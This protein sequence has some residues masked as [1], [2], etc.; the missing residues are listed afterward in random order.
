VNHEYEVQSKI[1]ATAPAILLEQRFKHIICP[2]FPFCSNLHVLDLVRIF[3]LVEGAT[4][5]SYQPQSQVSSAYIIVA[6]SNSPSVR[7]H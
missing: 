6:A 4:R 1:M 3:H 7:E 2:D 5:R